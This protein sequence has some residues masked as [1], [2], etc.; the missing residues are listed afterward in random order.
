MGRLASSRASGLAI[1]AG[2]ENERSL[3]GGVMRK[4]LNFFLFGLSWSLGLATALAQSYPERPVRLVVGFGAG[5]S[6]DTTARTLAQKLS[7]HWGQQV[8]VDNRPGAAG[9]IAM[10]IVEKTA[11]DGYTLMI[12]SATQFSVGP[13]LGQ[14]QYPSLA[15]FTPIAK[16]VV[17]PAVLTVNPSVTAHSLQ[18]LIQ[19]AKSRSAPLTFGSTGLS[20]PNHIAMTLIA[21]SGG[22]E[23]VH[24]PYKGGAEV[25]TAA[26]AGH[27]PVAMGSFSTALP[28][29]KSGRLRALGVTESK[30][31]SIA[32]D[33]PTIAESG[34]PGFEVSQWFGIFAPAGIPGAITEKIGTDLNTIVAVPDV[35]QRLE[36]LGLEVS[37]AGPKEFGSYVK[38]ELARW[39]KLIKELGI[40]PH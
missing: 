11:R 29:I 14:A 23:I 17:A 26:V 39:T 6:A 31:L 40:K 19:Y 37:Y 27:V 38:S 34:I 30:R 24:V 16:V 13:A 32:P 25:I 4:A 33:L 15:N 1:G 9:A 2:I 22:F 5:G 10:Q 12:G 28:H 7:E 35:K 3:K 18:E 36:G 21:R 20:T 8:I